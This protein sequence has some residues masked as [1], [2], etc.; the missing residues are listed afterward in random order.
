M[1][2]HLFQQ[3]PFASDALRSMF[4]R[5]HGKQ[6]TTGVAD[7]QREQEKEAFQV[8]RPGHCANPIGSQLT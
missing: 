8:R 2:I 7:T 1:L 6:A 3:R 5:D 4:K